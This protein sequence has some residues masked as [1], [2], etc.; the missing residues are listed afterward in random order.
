MLT[1]QYPAEGA[2]DHDEMLKLVW[3]SD[4]LL[5]NHISDKAQEIINKVSRSSLVILQVVVSN[6]SSF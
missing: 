4:Y 3:D 1:F 6:A 5:P 2:R